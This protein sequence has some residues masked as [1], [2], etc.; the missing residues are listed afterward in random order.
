MSLPVK[1]AQSPV[2]HTLRV[3]FGSHDTCTTTRVRKNAGNGCATGSSAC[4]HDQG[5]TGSLPVTWLITWLTSLPVKR[6]YYDGYC[7]TSSC[8]CAEHTSGQ[9]LFRSRDWRHFR[10]RDWRQLRSRDFRSLHLTAP[11]QMRLCPCPYT[12]Q[13]CLYISNADKNRLFNIKGFPITWVNLT[14][15]LSNIYWYY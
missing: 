14:L 5:P 13:A 10:S 7:A 15:I 6:P 8:T 9:G 11:P 2:A 12:T 1:R 4:A 3:T